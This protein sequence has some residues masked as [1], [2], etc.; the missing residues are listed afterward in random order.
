MTE[1]E[2][3][4][5]INIREKSEKT[6]L[7]AR[8]Y[9]ANLAIATKGKSDFRSI[10]AAIPNSNIIIAENRVQEAE[11]KWEILKQFPNPKH[12]IG[13]LQKN[14]VRKAVNLFSVIQTVDSLDLLRR[15]DRIAKEENKTLKILFHL[16]ISEDQNKSGMTL[17]ELEQCVIDITQTPPSNT[18]P[19]GLFTILKNDLSNDQKREFYKIMKKTLTRIQHKLD[20]KLF[21]ELSMGM[22]EDY[23]I[24]LEEGAT[25]VRVG[26]GIFGEREKK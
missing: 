19:S 12:F 7:H 15:I 18:I 4:K 3:K 16:N 13:T 6:Y 2:R 21:T 20:S 10:Y 22:S 11:E 14:K 24:A 1:E 8:W 25:I 17:E 9:N 26:R 5:A 23:H